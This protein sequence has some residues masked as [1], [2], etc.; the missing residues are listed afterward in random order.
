MIFLLGT[1]IITFVFALFADNTG[2]L[3]LSNSTCGTGKHLSGAYSDFVDK[4]S[5]AVSCGGTVENA[6]VS[7]RD[8]ISGRHLPQ[9]SVICNGTK[10]EQ[11]TELTQLTL[12]TVG[13]HAVGSGAPVLQMTNMNMTE[14]VIPVDSAYHCTGRSMVQISV[15][16]TELANR[17]SESV[18]LG[19]YDSIIDYHQMYCALPA[20]EVHAVAKFHCS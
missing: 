9:A 6:V 2:L 15:F 20:T 10:E 12:A 13:S 1:V 19:Y 3:S 14:Q 5:Y 4:T 11:V 8:I 17:A 16:S 18:R 7:R